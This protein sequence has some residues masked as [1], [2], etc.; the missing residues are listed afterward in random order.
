MAFTYLFL[1]ASTTCSN[2][3][4]TPDFHGLGN[5]FVSMLAPELLAIRPDSIILNRGHDGFTVPFLYSRLK[6]DLPIESPDHITL[7]IGINDV[8]V[9]MNTGRSLQ[10]QDFEGSYDR[11]LNKL[12]EH[13]QAEI[14]CLAPFLFPHP[15]EYVNWIPQVH[16]VEQIIKQQA[17]KHNVSFLPLH[18]TLNEIAKKEGYEKITTDGIHLTSYGHRMLAEILLPYYK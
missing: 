3:F 8:G 5:G 4:W 1:G 10:E 14:L 11:L 16:H 12:Q 15:Q 13:T 7:L 18:D 6:N 17:K 2:R 9:A